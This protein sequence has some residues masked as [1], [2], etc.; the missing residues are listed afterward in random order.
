MDINDVKGTDIETYWHGKMNLMVGLCESMGVPDIF[1]K[2]LDSDC[3]RTPDI[4]YGVLAEMLIVNICS[5]HRPLYRLKDFYTDVDLE[6]IFHCEIALN[7]ITDDRFG[8][9]LDKVY[10]A[11]AR[12]IFGEISSKAFT[13]HNITVKN[14]NYDTTS[15]VMWGEY[16]TLEGKLGAISIDFGHSKQKREDKKQI[17][18]GIGTANG[19]IIDAKVLSGNKDDK[20]YNNEN[21]DDVNSVIERFDIDKENFYYIADSALFTKENL[22]KAKNKIKLITRMPD[23][24]LVAKELVETTLSDRA[25]MQ[26]IVLENAQGKKVQYFLTEK[27]AVY[28]DINLKC[29]V[30]YSTSLEETKKKT[31]E[32]KVIKEAESIEKLIKKYSK[33]TFACQKDANKEIELITKKDLAKLRFFNYNIDLVEKEKRAVGRPSTK[34]TD[35]ETQFKYEL[36]IAFIKDEVKIAK[37]IEREC[38]FVLCSNDLSITGEAIL[39]EYKTQSSIE[40]KFQ[41]LKSPQFVNSLYLNS[42]ERIEALTYIILISMMM[43]SVSEYVVRAGLNK[44]KAFII[45]PGQLKMTKTTLKSILEIFDK[46]PMKVFIV[47]G[48]KQRVIGRPFNDS[49]SKILRYLLIPEEVFCWNGA[50]I[51]CNA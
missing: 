15:M 8:L 36:R 6:G 44:E 41:Q 22:E 49:Q 42:P 16:E 10:A 23:N 3:G 19:V 4:P 33:R 20:T 34:Q 43:L 12:R 30:C 7:K 14:I 48:K 29:A 31:I 18:L 2:C 46:V 32:K 13:L 51:V 50:R 1:N 21:L 45:G 9:L 11:G 37:I 17:K 28:K 35:K 47:D 40:K 5:T 26:E 27:T 38:T 39:L 24:T 25:S